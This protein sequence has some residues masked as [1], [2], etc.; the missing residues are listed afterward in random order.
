MSRLRTEAARAKSLIGCL[1]VR[2]LLRGDEGSQVSTFDAPFVKRLFESDSEGSL[3]V[4]VVT[5]LLK[6]GTTAAEW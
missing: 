6:L 3:A 4:L 2:R 1:V 5:R